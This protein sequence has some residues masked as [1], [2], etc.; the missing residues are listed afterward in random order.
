MPYKSQAQQAFFHANKA[1]LQK[2]GVNVSEWDESSKGLK[3]P[4]R[5]QPKAPKPPR[6]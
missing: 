6:Q 2:Q 4:P 5:K 3:L 1:K